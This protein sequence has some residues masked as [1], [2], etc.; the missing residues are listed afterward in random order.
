MIEKRL[1][2]EYPTTQDELQVITD[3]SIKLFYDSNNHNRVATFDS[4]YESKTV[5]FAANRGCDT[6]LLL[7]G[8]IQVNALDDTLFDVTLGRAWQVT[9][10][11]YHPKY[12]EVFW[13]DAK[14]GI[15][16]EMTGY[17][18]RYV[19]GQIKG[20]NVSVTT[21]DVLTDD[22]RRYDIIFGRIT[23]AGD[24]HITAAYSYPILGYGQGKLAEDTALYLG[25]FVTEG[26]TISGNAGTL[27]LS[28]TPGKIMRVGV[29]GMGS[30]PNV[31]DVSSITPKGYQYH[32]QGVL[33]TVDTQW[34]DPNY[35]DNAGVK[36]AVPNEHY[37]IQRIYYFAG[38]ENKHVTY[39]QKLYSS[40]NEAEAAINEDI[41]LNTTTL[42]GACLLGSVIM[43]S[44]IT[45]FGT[46]DSK[47]VSA[48]RINQPVHYSVSDIAKASRYA[49]GTGV[50]AG[51][52]MTVNSTT[53]IDITGGIGTI[54][55]QLE[56][57]TE[58][59]TVV[60]DDFT[61]V[62]ITTTSGIGHHIFIDRYSQI[63]QIE[64]TN[65][66]VLNPEDVRDKIYLGFVS[67]LVGNV[68]TGINNTPV[69]IAA[70]ANS[71]YEFAKAVGPFSTAGNEITTGPALALNIAA[72]KSF[73]Y[74][75]NFDAN[76]N[77]PHFI[78]SNGLTAPTLYAMKQDAF[79][80]SLGTTQIPV[81]QWDDNGTLTNLTAS[82]D[83]SAHRI[84]YSPVTDRLFFQY[85]QAKYGTKA[86]ALNGWSNENFKA[87]NL[88]SA[89]GYICAIIIIDRAASDFTNAE[90]I[91]YS[92]FGGAGGGSGAFDTCQSVYNN[93][94]TPEITTDATRGA[95]TIKRGSTADTDNVIEVKNGAS[96][97]TFAV[98][99][100]GL[101]KIVDYSL[102]PA[103]GSTGQVL[104]QKSD[105][106]SEWI[107][108]STGGSGTMGLLAL[109]QLTCTSTTQNYKYIAAGTTFNLININTDGTA[110]KA[111]VTFTAPASGQVRI[112]AE[113]VNSFYPDYK[114]SFFGIHNSETA[115]DTPEQWYAIQA[116]N[117]GVANTFAHIEFFYTG[118]TPGQSYTKYLMACSGDASVTSNQVYCGQYRTVAITDDTAY[119]PPFNMFVYDLGTTSIVTNPS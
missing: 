97:T 52:V 6:G 47:V 64:I 53:E 55:K 74:G 82:D 20:T 72:G 34:L 65:S 76:P 54:T 119:Y 115:T 77:V 90:L 30:S 113:F 81:T 84:W 9:Y 78:T 73:M 96:D 58:I 71:L 91:P 17:R 37:T 116:D 94:S 49:A 48:L 31:K 104:A 106:T 62:P 33:T 39:G 22:N 101:V 4:N 63:Y 27:G 57:D 26:L 68:I 8:D 18:S 85:G 117:D 32:L 102:P 99:G 50:I 88:A 13:D 98:D 67:H 5:G 60:W 79:I 45:A 109:T 56:D 43:K 3:S 87:P 59:V 1:G 15:D 114:K 105:G 38:S 110:R 11:P 70:A 40:L 69:A 112:R 10:D 86:A 42:N 19:I 93:S 24:A 75:S 29:N 12:T 100:N 61:A 14:V 66:S 103:K 44:G 108:P 107:T 16:G 7:G 2:W 118:L 35:Y 89:N 23:G 95:L 36:T 80:G 25:S 111:K 21:T 92:K 46:V 51:G 41:V 83:W 28:A